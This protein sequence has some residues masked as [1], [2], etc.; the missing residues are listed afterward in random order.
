MRQNNSNHIIRQAENMEY[1]RVTPRL[2]IFLLAA[3]LLCTFLF[4]KTK[5]IN[6]F[7]VVVAGMCMIVEAAVFLAANKK[8]TYENIFILLFAGGFIIRLYY[9]LYTP[10]SL[11][12][13]VR[14]HDLW[15]FGKGAGHAGYIEHFYNEPFKLPDFNPISVS[16]FYHPPVHY[17]TMAMWMRFLTMF[18]ISY[19]RAVCS[20]QYLT[21]FYSSCCMLVGE[22]ILNALDIDGKGKIIAF[23]IIAFHPSFILLAGSINNDMLSTLFI[24]LSIYTTIKWYKD[25]NIK[26]ILL[27]AL[28]IGLG[29]TT[30]LSAAL[31]AFPVALVFLVKFIK[32]I[33]TKGGWFNYF[34]QYCVFGVVCI[35]LGMW[36]SVRNYIVYNVPFNYVMRLSDKLDQYVGNWSIA[37]RLFDF[38]DF[39]FD[40]VYICWPN[41]KLF[42][43]EY[44]PTISML[45]SSMFG[46]YNFAADNANMLL[47]SRIL[48][49]INIFLVIIS[50]LSMLYCCIKNILDKKDKVMLMIFLF[51]YQIITYVNFIIFSI[52]YPHT[53]SMDYRYIVPTCVVGSVFIGM[54]INALESDAECTDKKGDDGELSTASNR[55]KLVM[56]NTK[57][58]TKKMFR[59]CIIILSVLF[60]LF[61]FVVYLML[62]MG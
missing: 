47:P 7:A 52:Q 9:V 61:S 55:V 35:P 15:G 39:S 43:S 13:S 5:E 31:V 36:F 12:Y 58:I 26:N 30:K 3:C 25:S 42:F 2:F 56:I 54:M 41:E 46:E 29:M 62:G 33:K 14:Q 10:V 48:L 16:Q 23:S 37:D 8:L 1:D 51:F 53:C 18:G 49:W 17:F 40:Y 45:K 27:V 59:W 32:T 24:L 11:T 21:L 57:H 44:N 4:D 38:W 60:A 22:R 20:M 50:V 19:E 6:S 34:K 28:S